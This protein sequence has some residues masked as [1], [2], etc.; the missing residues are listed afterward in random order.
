MLLTKTLYVPTGLLATL[1]NPV[2]EGF[3]FKGFI[4]VHAG[5]YSLNAQAYIYALAHTL[6]ARNKFSIIR[7]KEAFMEYISSIWPVFVG[8]K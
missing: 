1:V 2:K 8:E 5:V 4:D 3:E 6:L 7:D